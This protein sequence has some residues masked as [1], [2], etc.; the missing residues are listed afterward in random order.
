MPALH[1]APEINKSVAHES[2]RGL[3]RH[4]FKRLQAGATIERDFRSRLLIKN[5]L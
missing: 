5:R 1:L 3:S 2:N 4:S